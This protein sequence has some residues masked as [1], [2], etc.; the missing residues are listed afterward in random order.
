MASLAPT[1]VTAGVTALVGRTM[2]PEVGAGKFAKVGAVSY[3]IPASILL[4][5]YTLSAKKVVAQGS[6]S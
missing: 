6:A 1:G 4:G 5:V 2:Y 3:A